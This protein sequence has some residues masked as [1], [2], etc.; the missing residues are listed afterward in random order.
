MTQLVVQ[1]S[2]IVNWHSEIYG[3]SNFFDLIYHSM[4]S[5]THK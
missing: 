5:Y 3:L 2:G 4:W 1:T